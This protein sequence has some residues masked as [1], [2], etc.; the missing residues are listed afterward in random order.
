MDYQKLALALGELDD[1]EVAL[2]LAREAVDKLLASRT[3]IVK[4]VVKGRKKYVRSW[5]AR[6]TMSRA[7]KACWANLSTE[8]REAWAKNIGRRRKNS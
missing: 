7:M 3:K 1:A 6:R 4:I 2:R 5:H 8:K